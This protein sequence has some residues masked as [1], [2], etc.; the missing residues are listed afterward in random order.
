MGSNKKN[1]SS[2]GFIISKCMLNMTCV[3][4]GSESCKLFCKM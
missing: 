3:G 1:Y 2:R 4:V